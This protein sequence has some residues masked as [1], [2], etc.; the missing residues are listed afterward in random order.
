MHSSR[1]FTQMSAAQKVQ[2]HPAFQQVSDKANYY[3]SQID[4]E[5]SLIA[6]P[7]FH[8]LSLTTLISLL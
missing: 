3:V 1:Y 6:Y 5:V 7:E 4:K 8:A 2:Q